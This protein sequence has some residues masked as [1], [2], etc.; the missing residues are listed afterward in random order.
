MS[1]FWSSVAVGGLFVGSTI[2]KGLFTVPQK[3]P[4]AKKIPFEDWST[5]QRIDFGIRLLKQPIK[6]IGKTVKQLIGRKP[7]EQYSWTTCLCGP[8]ALI[9]YTVC[10]GTLLMT[11]KDYQ[12]ENEEFKAL[13]LGTRISRRLGHFMDN[14]RRITRCY[15]FMTFT[16]KFIKKPSNY[17]IPVLF[18]SAMVAIKVY[19]GR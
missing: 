4:K 6:I 3:I 11:Y 14:S 16:Y 10:A 15:A 8:N 5:L 1:N 12:K 2:A 9:V 17:A 7:L 13:S 19:A 18:A